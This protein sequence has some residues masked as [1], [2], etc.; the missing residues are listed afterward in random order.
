MPIQKLSSNLEQAMFDDQK[1]T[2]TLSPTNAQGVPEAFATAPT[3]TV[4]PGTAVTITPSADGVTCLVT[5]I[6]NQAGD[7]VV[8]ASYTNPDGS[9]ADP[10]TF[11][12]HQSVD[13]A[14]GDIKSLGGSISTPVSQ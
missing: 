6:T 2:I 7:E 4:A 8:T 10:S 5:G 1:A 9:V 11:T 3:Y 12:F 13:P 14:E